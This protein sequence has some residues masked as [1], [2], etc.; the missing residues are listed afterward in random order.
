M[1][2]DEVALMP[3]F[4]STLPRRERPERRKDRR[5]T[6]DFN[7]RSHEGS[8]HCCSFPLSSA[9]DF[10]PRSHEG[11]D[12]TS[13]STPD[14]S[15]ISIHAPTKGA[16]SQVTKIRNFYSNFNPR[17]HEGSDVLCHI[18]MSLISE[19]QSTLPRRERHAT[20]FPNG[21]NHLY[22]NPRSHEG[23]DFLF[24]RKF[25]VKRRFQSTLPRRERRLT[26]IALSCVK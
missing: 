10:N 2:F 16:T 19:F 26:D 1:F 4:Q 14:I 13:S 18:C 12:C 20:K 25:N 15:N 24:S 17:S 9:L 5:Q 3:E 23:S 6:R 8:D 21:S 11:S 22:F 7:P